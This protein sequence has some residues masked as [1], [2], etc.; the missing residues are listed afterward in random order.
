MEEAQPSSTALGA[1]MLRAAHQLLDDPPKIFDDTFALRLCG[2]ENETGLRVQLDQ[3][4]AEIARRA[5]IDF[6]QTALHH[7]RVSVIVRSRYVED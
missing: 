5:S 6:A 1:A 7:I 3:V 2:C 4:A